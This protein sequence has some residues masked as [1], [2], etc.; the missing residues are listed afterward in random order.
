M[1]K[2]SRAYTVEETRAL[3]M[4]Q[5]R[6]LVEYWKKVDSK[7]PLDGLAHSFLTMIDGCGILPEFK[8]LVNPHPEDMAF[9]Q[10]ENSNWFEPDLWINEEV[11][12]HDDYYQ[13]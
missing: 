10:E 11:M 8:L 3:F 1:T 9:H 6:G 2:T 12:L 4:A 5:V 7:D 13:T